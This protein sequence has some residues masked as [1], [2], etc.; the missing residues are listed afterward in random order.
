MSVTNT[1]DD[2]ADL[3]DVPGAAGL[4][5]AAQGITAATSSVQQP[6][7]QPLAASS[8]QEVR[9]A[10]TV[11]I[12]HCNRAFLTK[13]APAELSLEAATAWLEEA[14]VSRNIPT[15]RLVQAFKVVEKAKL[16]VRARAVLCSSTQ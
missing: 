2:L 16:P 11:S 14:A 1:P 12:E 5:R 13:P 15:E 7:R 9:L 3:T 6:H 4:H 10:V 8:L